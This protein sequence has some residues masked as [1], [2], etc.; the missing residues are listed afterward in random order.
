MYLLSKV[1]DLTFKVSRLNEELSLTEK[2]L[3]AVS[4]NEEQRHQ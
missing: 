3:E 4:D 2:E 1:G